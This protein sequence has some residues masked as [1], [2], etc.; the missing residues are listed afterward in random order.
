MILNWSVKAPWQ[1]IYY[2]IYRLNKTTS[3][4]D[5][6]GTSNTM[7]YVDTGLVNGH[8]YCYYVRS[9]GSY[10]A[11]GFTNPIDNNSET[12]CSSP[13]D[14]VKPCPP[15]L[16]GI[17]DCESKTT[18]LGWTTNDSCNAKVVQYDIYYSTGNSYKFSYIDSV[19]GINTK[20]YIDQR[21]ILS[22]SLAGCY[23]VT[24]I[25]SYSN[26]SRPSNYVCVDNC[27]RYM[28]PNVFTPNG[29]EIN[30]LFIPFPGYQFIQ[31]IDLKIYNRWGQQVFSSTDPAINWDGKDE[32]THQRLPDGVYYYSC[33]VKQIRF[34]GIIDVPLSGTV[35]IISKK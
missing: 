6:I 5:S 25:D 10:L 16:S 30:D 19:S 31:G 2:I 17:A 28:L 35:S 8:P 3:K 24:A 21:K 27:P 14:T 7:S 4:W 33:M 13:R 18:S 34:E 15:V 12:R 9:I 1:N 11:P 26:Q 23:Y 29:D 20:N 32:K 22:Y